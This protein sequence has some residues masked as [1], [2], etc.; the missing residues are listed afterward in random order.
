MAH[1]SVVIG[2][3]HVVSVSQLEAKDDTPLVVNG[4]RVLAFTRTGECVES[5][6]WRHSQILKTNSQITI[7][8]PAKRS[9]DE[10]GRKSFRFSSLE[11]LTSVLFGKG[12][13]HDI[14]VT[15][16]VTFVKRNG[17]CGRWAPDEHDRTRIKTHE[18]KNR[19]QET[20]EKKA[21]GR[22]IK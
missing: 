8:K 11:K 17:A 2:N 6:A 16:H 10:L 22:K 3:L 20:G 13:D 18:A 4:N 21:R 14:F 15:C 19:I 9:P 1:L 5:I 7:F 12:F